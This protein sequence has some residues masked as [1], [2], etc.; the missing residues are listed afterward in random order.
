VRLAFGIQEL[1]DGLPL[2][3]IALGLFGLPEVMRS[4]GSLAP[5]AASL[6]DVRL[7]DMLPTRE[8]WRRSFGA[9][10]RGTGIGAFFGA[11]PGTGGTIASF[12]SYAVERKSSRYPEQFGHGAIEG[13][14]G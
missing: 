12:I 8:D 4:A 2:V 6:R 13:I 10:A 14:A 5:V 7:R 11:L 3:A 1:Y 9:I